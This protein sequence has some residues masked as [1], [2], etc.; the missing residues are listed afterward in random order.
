MT[1]ADDPGDRPDG[2]QHE[3]LDIS[4]MF[5]RPGG[6]TEIPKFSLP[7]KQTLPD[8]AYQVVHDEAM[9]DGNA[10]LNLATFVSTWMDD[11]ARRIYLES[12]DKN[13]ID[14]DEYPATAA[15][16]ERCW[17]ILADLWHAPDPKSA[18][19][20][21]TI[22][23]S[24][25]CMLGGLAL[26][27]AWQHRRRAAGQSTERP[28]V[29]MSSAVQVCWEKFCN[30]FEVE[31]RYVPI[32][33]DHPVL[34]GH[35]LA[36]YVDENTIG[37]I[38]ILGVTYTG[39][40]EPVTQISAA[41]DDIERD[42]GLDVAIHV[43]GASGAMV[44]PFAQPDLVWDFTLPRVHSINTS[45]HKYGLVYPGVGWVVWRDKAA[46]PDD[47]VFTVSYLGGD[48]PTFA[49]NFSRP[50]AQVLMQYYLFLRLGREGFTAVQR[51]SLDVAQYLADGIAELPAFELF[52]HPTDIPVFA[53]KL[54]AGYTD[55]WDLY[56]L[57]DMLRE[58][59]WL[60]PAYPMPDDLTD[61]TVQ[62]IVVRNGLSMDL[63]GVLLGHIRDAVDH[64]DQ[65]TGPIPDSR[66][67][68]SF[69]H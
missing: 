19:G 18:V 32:S 35:R 45:G 22:G 60:V 14:K 67:G 42:T 5:V 36:E 53:W 27:R 16:E 2:D 23:S 1:P 10:R 21:S 50:G 9:L 25:A 44:A 51:A 38:A 39:M 56:H 13:M 34:D 29:V 55:N 52:N 8:T 31:A 20:T 47:L 28:N 7:D 62:R 17:R 66:R 15:I 64:L 4:P 59:G 69:H 54:R 6:V 12:A 65:L 40:Y 11:H 37:V 48:M 3:N 58:S 46:L 63:A 61:V 30:Y 33:E 41:L 43:D 68:E 24:E 26:K 49:L 57:S